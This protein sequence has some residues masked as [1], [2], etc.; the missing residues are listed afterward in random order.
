MGRRKCILCGVS[1]EKTEATFHSD[2]SVEENEINLAQEI[3]LSHSNSEQLE[4]R[5]LPRCETPKQMKGKPI[6]NLSS[7]DL[8]ECFPHV[9]GKKSHR[10]LIVMLLVTIVMLF[11]VIFVLIRY[12]FSWLAANRAVGPNSPY[13]PPSTPVSVSNNPF[14]IQ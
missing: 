9:Y 11:G 2:S 12:P 1:S 3:A 8:P 13:S 5:D 14:T 4:S 7:T 10:I 6:T